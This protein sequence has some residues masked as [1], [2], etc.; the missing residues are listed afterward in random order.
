MHE[1]LEGRCVR[2]PPLSNRRHLLRLLPTDLTT[3]RLDKPDRKAPDDNR[4]FFWERSD[5]RFPPCYFMLDA[6][7]LPLIDLLVPP[8]T[9]K[10][11]LAKLEGE[12]F[13]L[14]AYLRDFYIN[15]DPDGELLLA[16]VHDAEGCLR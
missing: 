8:S 5:P 16:K 2:F 13:G 10:D 3:Q 7:R 1:R 9:A 6:I 12:E 14:A 15:K 11:D 4:N